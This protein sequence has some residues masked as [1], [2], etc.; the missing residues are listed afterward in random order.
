MTLNR[1]SI[2]WWVIPV[3]WGLIQAFGPPSFFPKWLNNGISSASVVIIV[4]ALVMLLIPNQPARTNRKFMIFGFD[5]SHW[6]IKY[7]YRILLGT[8]F[9]AFTMGVFL[10]QTE[11]DDSAKP[12]PLPVDSHRNVATTRVD[13]NA[14]P[15]QNPDHKV[16]VNTPEKSKTRIFTPRTPKELINIARTKT[17]R[18][19]LRHKG[20][21]IHVEG[22]VFDISEVTR[23]FSN[24][25]PK[26]YIELKV[27]IGP[28]PYDVAFE[29]VKLYVESERW[30]L[31][32]DK[33]ERDDW[34]VAIGTVDNISRWTVWVINGEIISVSGLDRKSR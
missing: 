3:C 29:E 30:K 10:S 27:A 7:D 12:T 15:G 13:P 26:P 24:T 25:T 28:P 5:V 19:A 9:L 4:V 8:A 18:D 16:I 21:W 11:S 6:I 32:V 14:T 31:Q 33:I 34:L 17:K 20:A 22:T 2:L 23:Y 1:Q